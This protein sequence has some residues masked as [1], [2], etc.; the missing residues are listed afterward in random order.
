MAS[1]N[2]LERKEG[3]KLCWDLHNKTQTP[4]HGLYALENNNNNKQKKGL[5]FRNIV[6]TG[7]KYPVTCYS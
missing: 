3:I 7:I 4:Q 2:S 5:T 6:H 1:G